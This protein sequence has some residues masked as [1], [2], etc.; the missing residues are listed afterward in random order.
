MALTRRELLDAAEHEMAQ[1]TVTPEE[2]VKRIRHGYNGKPYNYKNTHNWKAQQFMFQ[3]VNTKS[4]PS[5]A[6]LPTINLRPVQ[7]CLFLTGDISRALE[8]TGRLLI[9]TADLNYRQFYTTQFLQAAI[10]S[11]R[12]RVWCD[13]RAAPNGTPPDV[14]LQWLRELGLPPHYFYGQ[15]EMPNEFDAAYAAG[16]RRMVG[17]V[18]A[19]FSER[20]IAQIL[21]PDDPV[22][23]TNETYFNVNPHYDV[24]WRGWPVVGSNTLACYASVSEGASYYPFDQ[25]HADG[26]VS[27][28][29]DCFYMDGLR[30][31]DWDFIIHT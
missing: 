15:C 11:D 1:A 8:T 31:R 17:N 19:P 3:A 2:W 14:A 12:L 23:I 28:G 13:S 16:A 10:A 4:N 30:S 26:K 22:V 24:N 6:P 27:P 25:Q 9:A 18:N 21:N 7:R 29:I 20:Q 5:P